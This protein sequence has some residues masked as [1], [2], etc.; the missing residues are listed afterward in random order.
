MDIRGAAVETADQSLSIYSSRQPHTL[1]LFGLQGSHD[2]RAGDHDL[3]SFDILR[4]P[5]L[6]FH[7]A[8]WG[9]RSWDN[10]VR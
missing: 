5:R 2:V 6:N 10:Q 1:L 9:V 7:A 3:A 4:P 8:E